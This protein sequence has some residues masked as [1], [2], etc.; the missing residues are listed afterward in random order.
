MLLANVKKMWSTCS[1]HHL[2]YQSTTKGVGKQ[3][4]P[5][6]IGTTRL[7]LDASCNENG[8]SLSSDLTP[9]FL[10]PI[11]IKCNKLVTMEA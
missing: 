9:C 6:S 3:A 10:V 11:I 7:D 2:Y 1:T 8:L 5:L 4:C